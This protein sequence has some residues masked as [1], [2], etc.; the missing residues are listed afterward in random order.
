MSK[1]NLH[2]QHNLI[3]N[4]NTYVYEQKF[5]SINSEDRDSLRYPDASLFE[6]ELPQ[7][8]CNVQSVQLVSWSFP[9][10]YN[11]FSLATDNLI[12]VFTMQDIYNPLDNGINDPLLKAIY[13]GLNLS[14]DLFFTIET[15]F[16]NP[17]QMSNEIMNKMN[18][19]VTGYLTKFFNE[20]PEY[21]YAI[22]LFDGY[23]DFVV[24]YNSVAQRLLFG[25]KSSGFTFA[26]NSDFYRLQ[27]ISR[28]GQCIVT[29][30]ALPSFSSWGLPAY[31]GFTRIPEKSTSYKNYKDVR[32]SYDTSKQ[33]YWLRP[34][35][36]GASVHLIRAPLKINFMGPSYLYMELDS[37]TSLNCIDETNPFEANKFTRETNQTNGRVNASFAKI[38]I[39][40]TPLSQWYDTDQPAYKW[41]DPPAEKIRK[42]RIKI[43][44]HDNI[45][46]DFGSFN[47]SFLLEFNILNPQIQRKST[48]T[49][50][51]PGIF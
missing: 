27:R 39:P 6:I 38:A 18:D 40:T 21:N 5:V 20:T 13:A 22:E 1:F 9:A 50:S 51:A 30:R 19:S 45:L 8:Y 31:L 35:L 44:F 12:M 42:L 3:P 43:R 10:N 26:N 11:V 34:I 24:I 2:R 37:T 29:P 17:T 25:N 33:S 28:E 7:D 15:G 49:G 14:K 32:L 16:Y 41:F 48:I 36:K 4:A 46:V 47:Y 23:S